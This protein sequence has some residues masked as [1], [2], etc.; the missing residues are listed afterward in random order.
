[1]QIEQWKPI[2]GC[3]GYWVSSFGNVK[4]T[5]FDRPYITSLNRKGYLII[6]IPKYKFS[7]SVHR[8]VAQ[9]FIGDSILQ[10][11]HIDGNKLNNN[12]ANLEY[13]TCKENIKHAIE[14]GLRKANANLKSKAMFTNVD[15]NI[16]R[17]AISHGFK[18]TEIASYYK[19]N[20]STISKI[21]RGSH[22]TSIT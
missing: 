18:N 8:V 7:K 17:D 3:D 15:I 20:H 13:V 12:V 22:Y 9:H 21:R 10:V 1:M 4:G 11:N 6:R 19:C 2:H 14:N 16:I 5:R